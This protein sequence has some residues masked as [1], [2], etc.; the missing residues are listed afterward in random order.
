MATLQTLLDQLRGDLDEPV[1]AVWRN[2]DLTVWLNAGIYRAQ[3][4]LK[5]TREDWQTLRRK[6]TDG[7]ITINGASYDC[8][9]FKLVTSTAFYTLPPDLLEI[10]VMQPASQADRDA[11]I[12][13]LPRELAS[14]DFQTALRLQNSTSTVEGMQYL[15]EL[16]GLNQLVIAPTPAQTIEIELYYISFAGSLILSDA[17]TSIPEFAYGAAKAY[18]YYRALRSVQHPDTVRAQ[19]AFMDEKEELKSY[20]QPRKSQD[21]EITEGVFDEYDQFT[22]LWYSP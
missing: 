9:S 15:Y 8:A 2:T 1:E 6:S 13:F 3:S 7:T 12:A 14:L 5:G 11:G 21:P 4:V 10:R 22:R 19:Q 16:I 20:A 18:A 17:I